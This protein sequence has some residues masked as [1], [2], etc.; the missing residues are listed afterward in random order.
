MG[1]YFISRDGQRLLVKLLREIPGLVEDLVVTLTRQDRTSKGGMKI[2]S[3]D[4]NQP[5]P[6][7]MAASD[8]KEGLRNELATW[9]RLVCESRGIVYD[10]DGSLLGT[11]R[12]LDSNMIEL[13][14]T[15]GVEDAY[16]GI[17]KEMGKC[18]RAMDIA[19][20]DDV[21]LLTKSDVLERVGD[22]MLHRAGIVEVA[23]LLAKQY[24][25]FGGLTERRVDTL[26]RS[27]RISARYCGLLSRAEVFRFGDVLRAHLDA[28]SRRRK[29]A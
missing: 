12:W 1:D 14:M 8:A 28:P 22:R 20:E 19:P 24:P 6:V 9:A 4:C 11:A 21:P 2:S 5:L 25:E 17:E 26:R 10:G 23:K 13:A 29:V 27:G 7:N 3:G 18:R 16:G 15:E